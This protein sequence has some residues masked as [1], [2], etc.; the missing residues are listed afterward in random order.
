MLSLGLDLIGEHM[1]SIFKRYFLPGF[2]FQSVVIGGGYATGREL[3]EFFFPAGIIGGLMAMMVAA[4]VWSATN[5]ACIEFARV[6]KAYDYNSFF[7]EL[8]GRWS[9]LFEIAFIALLVLIIST[10]SS[11]AGELVAN[12]FD[13]HSAYGTIAMMLL[14]AWLSYSGTGAIEKFLAG[15]SFLLYATYILF[16]LF[17]LSRFGSDISANLAGGTIEKG[18]AVSGVQYAGYNLATIPAILFCVKHLMSR[19]EA[20]ISG[21]LTGP[22]AI[23][24]AVLFYVAMMAHYEA[25][26]EQAMPISYMLEMLDVPWLRILFEVVL[27]GT[28]I[29][30][31]TAMVHSV[32]ERIASVFAVRGKKLPQRIRFYTAIGICLSVI[33][34]A[35]QLGLV[36]LIAKGYG[37]LTYVFIILIIIP[38][39]TIGLKRIAQTR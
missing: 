31:G 12:S 39:F 22:I 10:L 9:I 20:L 5:A 19:K 30:T 21:L 36:D 2:V 17:S 18:W 35:T 13:L 37:S 8:L 34:L 24:P 3:V 38:I 4:V 7:G 32:N 29:E 11:A 6:S 26:S 28:F 16:L 27:Y 25:L 14:I 15:W 33:L 23:A 1:A